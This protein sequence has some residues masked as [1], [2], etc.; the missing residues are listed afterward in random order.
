MLAKLKRSPQRLQLP[1][2]PDELV[3]ARNRLQEIKEAVQLAQRRRDIVAETA[4]YGRKSGEERQAA[5]AQQQELDA[6]L[7][8][9]V[10]SELAARRAYDEL[11]TAYAKTVR[12][13]MAGA[14]TAYGVA[15]AETFAS[16][17][18]LLSLGES[19]T[20]EAKAAG[21][22]LAVPVLDGSK[23]M[24]AMLAPLSNLVSKWRE[25]HG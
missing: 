22:N 17:D 7:K 12:D 19:F 5:K 11:L 3:D 24:R 1:P 21:L 4:E 9:L 14:F 20:E 16:L 8:E 18:E 25:Q 6:Q 2:A 15:V 10:P 23:R 13:V